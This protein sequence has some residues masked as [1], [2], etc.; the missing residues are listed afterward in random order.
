VPRGP[1]PQWKAR[2]E[3]TISAIPMV[4]AA[5]QLGYEVEVIWRGIATKERARTLKRG[6]FNASLRHDP[7][8]S[9]STDIK[10]SGNGEY[11]I[12]FVLHDKKVARA[13]IVTKHGT[14]RSAWPYNARARG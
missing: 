14:D 11:Q 1:A 10:P 12:H 7:P 3:H 8:V 13:Y 2:A 4:H 6:L 5:F 9:V